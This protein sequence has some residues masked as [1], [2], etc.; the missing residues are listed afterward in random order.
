[1]SK[2]TRKQILQQCGVA[3]SFMAA[4]P[5]FSQS[6][7]HY[8]LHHSATAKRVIFIH[9]HGGLS[10]VDSFDYKPEL[11]RMD[12][13]PYPGR[14]PTVTFS[15]GDLGLLKKSFA[16]FKQHGQSGAWVSDIFPQ[17][18]TIVDKLTFIKSMC[19][20]NVAHG[21]ACLKMNTGSATF[22]RPS[23][24]A[25]VSYALGTENENLPSF[26][27]IQPTGGHGG[28]QNYGAAFLP[29]STQGTSIRSK[30]EYMDGRY[31]MNDLQLMNQFSN[32]LELAK[33]LENNQNRNTLA[34]NRSLA[35]R[36]MQNSKDV[37][38]VDSESKETKKLY[39]VEHS[40]TNSF[41]KKCILARR[42]SESGTRFVTLTH[43]YW[44]SHQHI[45]DQ[46]KKAGQIDQPITALITD[47]ERRGLLDETLVVIGTEFG[48]MPVSNNH[49]LKHWGRDHNPDGF[50]YVLAGGGIQ[51]GL[52]YGETDPWGFYAVKNRVDYHDF[53]ATVLDL[54]G[55]DHER[56]T[57]EY[58]GREYRPTDVHGH[59]VR[60][61]MK[62]PNR[63]KIV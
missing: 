35:L 62:Q 43:S 25:W 60:E 48:R 23:M 55:L 61:I 59:V 28:L 57:F 13:K 63:S 29:G 5:L 39:G 41:A 37:F 30:I 51:P 31:D 2:S 8:P 18:S 46:R 52:S 33:N 45:Q 42:L 20:S 9:V 12:G 54:M 36:M 17:L 11:E 38:D 10:Q 49:K 4:S 58:M 26:I 50:T 19:G 56:L 27:P 40:N 3:A 1:M 6:K 24:G 44:D 21:G 15:N 14:K 22:I 53:H 34:K 7:A 47:L 32:E 16:T